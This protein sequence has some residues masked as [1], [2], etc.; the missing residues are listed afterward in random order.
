MTD[1][2]VTLR[3]PEPLVEKARALGLLTPERMTRLLAAELSRMESWAVLDAAL[4]PARESFRADHADLSEDE[5]LA[6]LSDL[7]REVR[8]EDQDDAV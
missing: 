1:I 6:M 2:D 4:Q 8:D 3:L 7:V 5:V